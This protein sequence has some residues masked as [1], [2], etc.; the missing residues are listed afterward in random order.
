MI[1]RDCNPLLLSF[2]IQVATFFIDKFKGFVVETGNGY[3]I[4][5]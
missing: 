1:I 5:S 3:S 2:R 4:L